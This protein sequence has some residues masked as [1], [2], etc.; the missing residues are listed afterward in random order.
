MDIESTIDRLLKAQRIAVVGLSDDPSRTSFRIA[1]FLQN[2]GKQIVP[3]NP[4]VDEVLGEKAYASL[5][6]VP[7][8][9]DLVNVFRRSEFCEQVTRDAI[10]AAAGGVWLQSGIVN[11]NARKL[12]EEAGMPFVQDRCIMVEM[13]SR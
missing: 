11:E 3:V 8:P 13:M 5:A 6:D 12:A 10:A 9:I 1:A 2:A 4:T 7:G